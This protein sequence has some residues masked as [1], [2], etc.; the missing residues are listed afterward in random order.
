MIKGLFG[1]LVG[2]LVGEHL[3][4]AGMGI[5][6]IVSGELAFAWLQQTSLLNTQQKRKGFLLKAKPL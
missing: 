3:G 5:L 6:S 1:C 2:W 4:K